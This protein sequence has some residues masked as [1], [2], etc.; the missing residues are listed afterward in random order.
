MLMPAGK[1]DPREER[2][3]ASVVAAPDGSALTRGGDRCSG[4]SHT[5][6]DPRL[7]PDATAWYYT[8]QA[9]AG[10]FRLVVW[11]LPGLGRSKPARDGKITID[12]FAEALGAVVR[13]AGSGPVIWSAIA[14]A[15]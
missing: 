5:R 15:G 1:D 2:G 12:R 11:D 8:K 4:P 14:S 3:E 13:S 7:G 9:F 6:I 10:R